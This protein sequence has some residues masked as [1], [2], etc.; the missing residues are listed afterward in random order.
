ML[1]ISELMS[2]AANNKV[3]IGGNFNAHHHQLESPGPCN[4]TGI[5]IIQTL[6]EMPGFRFLNNGEPTHR[7]GG[8]LDLSFITEELC[9]G[10]T[11]EV[12]PT[13][14]SDHFA[15][16]TSLTLSKM[17]PPPPPPKRWNHSK[18]DWPKFKH[19]INEWIVTYRPAEDIDQLEKDFVEA[20]Q[21]AADASIPIVV[22]TSHQHKDNWY[23][24]PEIKELNARMNRVRK[25]F[26]RNR[27]EENY[28]L[29]KEVATHVSA[30]MDAIRHD[31]WLEW[32]ASL[33]EHTQIG[34]LWRD[35]RRIAGKRIAAGRHQEPLEEA[36]RLAGVFAGQTS[37]ENLP[38]AT[39]RMQERLNEG[40]WER[41]EAACYLPDDTDCPFTTE[42]L[43]RCK[44][45]GKDTA[46]GAD[47]ISYSMI[48]WDQ[49]RKYCS[50]V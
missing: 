17:P 3:F 10:S 14:T 21:N 15:V 34:N 45:K 39:K 23:Y 13:L 1:D 32:C 29:L 20:L 47:R 8:R 30:E 50:L 24:C 44:H 7:D 49:E 41:I 6:D 43:R 37:S 5:H 9:E 40:R 33:N 38:P 27:T 42:E 36:N 28:E 26:R 12:H 35:L 22:P 16:Q 11:W 31:K 25:I 18:A 46:P 48:A 2:E 4:R 19:S